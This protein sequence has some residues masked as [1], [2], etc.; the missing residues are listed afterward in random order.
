MDPFFVR[1]VFGDYLLRVED[2][3]APQWIR[4]TRFER[5]HLGRCCGLG[6]VDRSRGR[7]SAERGARAIRETIARRIRIAVMPKGDNV[8]T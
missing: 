3:R 8:C 7:R 5:S 6:F 4:S 2:T 1:T